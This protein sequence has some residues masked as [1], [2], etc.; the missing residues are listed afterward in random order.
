RLESPV[1][2]SYSSRSTRNSGPRRRQPAVGVD[3]R[4]P[5]VLPANRD[6]DGYVE[7]QRKTEADLDV[8]VAKV[9][10][11]RLARAVWDDK[12]LAERLA[13]EVADLKDRFNRDF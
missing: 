2:R 9:R 13:R 3:D 1:Q 6:G 4:V 11:A 10:C 7:Y 8:Y 5:R 12:F